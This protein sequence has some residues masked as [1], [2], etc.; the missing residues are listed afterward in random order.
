VVRAGLAAVD[1]DQP[2]FDGQQLWVDWD[3]PI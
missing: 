1:I 2:L 3:E